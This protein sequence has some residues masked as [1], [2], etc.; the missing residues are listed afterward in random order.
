MNIIK[1]GILSFLSSHDIR[2]KGENLIYFFSDCVSFRNPPSSDLLAAAAAADDFP[3]SSSP[4]GNLR[5][6]GSRGRSTCR[7]QPRRKKDPTRRPRAGAWVRVD[8]FPVTGLHIQA[9]PTLSCCS[10]PSVVHL[11]P[12][13][14]TFLPISPPPQLSV[15]LFHGLGHFSSSLVPQPLFQVPQP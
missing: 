15:N 10:I 13:L 9:R 4:V 14:S 3:A 8:H 2:A 11:E 5:F 7:W 12:A 6:R 1:L